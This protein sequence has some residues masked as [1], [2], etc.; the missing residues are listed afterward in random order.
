MQR[1]K[2]TITFAT[3]MKIVVNTGVLLNDHPENYCRFLY[4]VLEIIVN[5]NREHEFIIITESVD[6]KKFLFGSNVT[7]VIR[8]YTLRHPLLLKIW[9]DIK[10]PYILKK[11]QADLFVS[12]D[13]FCSLTTRLRQCVLLNDLSLLP[14]SFPGNRQHLFFYKHFMDKILRRADVLVCWSDSKRKEL[15]LRYS[16]KEKKRFCVVYPAAKEIFQPL[17]E[18]VKEEVRKEYCDEKNYFIYSGAIQQQNDLLNLLKAFSVFKK[19]QQSNWKLVLTGSR[20]QYSKKFLNDL[21]SYKYRSDVVVAPNENQDDAARLIGSAYALI[22]AASADGSVFPILQA[23]RCQVPVVAADTPAGREIAGDAALYAHPEDPEN[24]ADQMMMLYK[25]ESLRTTL[26][27]KGKTAG[28]R[29]SLDK[30]AELL[31]QCI[32]GAR[33]DYKPAGMN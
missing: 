20:R 3:P 1:M 15:M 30:S 33:V 24:M 7:K 5:R 10:L 25:N 27:E 22:C 8:R 23:L 21:R 29:Y 28:A 14:Y 9:Y 4:E 6:V 18:K 12:F 2:R 31:W 11:Y 26:I 13:G 32:C 17:N 16:V 19:R